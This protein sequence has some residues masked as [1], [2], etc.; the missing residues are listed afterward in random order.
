MLPVNVIFGKT[1]ASLILYGRYF[2]PLLF[3]H[4]YFL[5]WLNSC[6]STVIKTLITHSP[7]IHHTMKACFIVD[8]GGMRPYDVI[9]L[10][11]Q[12]TVIHQ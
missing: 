12:G 3:F 8:V 4:L 2:S 1:N 5:H 11:L 6:N 10:A 9:G 7:L